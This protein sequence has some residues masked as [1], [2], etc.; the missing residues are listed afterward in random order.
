M[1]KKKKYNRHGNSKERYLAEWHENRM[2]KSY[3]TSDFDF[4]GDAARLNGYRSWQMKHIPSFE[5]HI[6]W[7][8]VEYFVISH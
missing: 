8:N 6:N 1:K 7:K 4:G 3:L 2:F 5:R